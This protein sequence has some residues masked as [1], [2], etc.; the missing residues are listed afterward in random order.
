VVCAYNP[1]YSKFRDWEDT[2]Y[3]LLQAKRY[4]SANKLGIVVQT[5]NPSY[6]GR[7]HRRIQFKASPRQKVQD[8]YLKNNLERKEFWRH[9]SSGGTSA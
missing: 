7:I 1:S 9:G 2:D 6:A 5:Y 4:I 3:M 8:L